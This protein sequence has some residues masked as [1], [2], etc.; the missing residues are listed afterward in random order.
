MK[1]VEHLNRD[2]FGLE[3]KQLFFREFDYL[4]EGQLPL[5]ATIVDSKGHCFITGECEGI[6]RHFT[7]GTECKVW[8]KSGMYKVFTVFPIER[9]PEYVLAKIPKDNFVYKVEPNF[10]PM[11]DSLIF[12]DNPYKGKS[13]GVCLKFIYDKSSLIE[14]IFIPKTLKRYFKRLDETKSKKEIYGEIYNA[15]TKTENDLDR[16]LFSAML[17]TLEKSE[18]YYASMFEISFANE[19][20]FLKNLYESKPIDWLS[21]VDELYYLDICQSIYGLDLLQDIKTDCMKGREKNELIKGLRKL[22]NSLIFS[23]IPTEVDEI[24]NPSH[25]NSF[26][27][28]LEFNK[29]KEII[30][31][32]SNISSYDEFLK[33][34]SLFDSK[35]IKVDN[36]KELMNYVLQ[37]STFDT[38][39]TE[40]IK[41]L[42]EIWDF[43]A[44]MH[45]IYSNNISN[46]N[47]FNGQKTLKSLQWYLNYG[48]ISLKEI[49]EFKTIDYKNSKKDEEEAYLSKILK[50][51]KSL[52]VRIKSGKKS[53]LELYK[54]IISYFDDIFVEVDGFK[55]KFVFESPIL[56]DVFSV[57]EKNDYLLSEILKN[58]NFGYV[59]AKTYYTKLKVENSIFDIL[60]KY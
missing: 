11:K 57:I 15:Y 32:S 21:I 27:G 51:F 20:S 33:I 50:A 7:F 28:D 10:T 44:I 60:N 2:Y 37:K 29:L 12:V 9:L 36:F 58:E 17:K 42:L 53:N 6:S 4:K 26:I 35:M 30:I 8:Y 39:R 25:K 54:T 49:E 55:L 16:A 47:V 13:T 56:Q 19:Y 45:S 46:I 48:N 22:K 43:I 31:N 24:K 14:C 3:E 5:N 52:K 23:G 41:D 18:K 1:K 38:N 34:I 40:M 59:D